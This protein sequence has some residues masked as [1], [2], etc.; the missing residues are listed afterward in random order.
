VIKK[1]KRIALQ[2]DARLC[3]YLYFSLYSTSYYSGDFVVPPAHI[4]VLCRLQ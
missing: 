3:V 2:I 1:D 4:L